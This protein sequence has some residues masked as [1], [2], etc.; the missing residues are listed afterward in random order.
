MFLYCQTLENN[1]A[2]FHDTSPRGELRT[3]HAHLDTFLVVQDGSQV[4]PPGVFW[5]DF[6][7]GATLHGGG[8]TSGQ[9]L[10]VCVRRVD[11]VHDAC[12]RPYGG[13]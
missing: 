1:L 10:Y 8:T 9:L 3:I 4:T 13:V 12:M 7:G 6:S 5:G 2:H 11:A